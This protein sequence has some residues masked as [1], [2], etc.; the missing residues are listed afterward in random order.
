MTEDMS[1]SNLWSEIFERVLEGSEISDSRIL[2][3]EN[4]FIKSEDSVF[5]ISEFGN[6]IEVILDVC[7]KGLEN[8]IYEIGCGNGL[9]ISTMASLAKI[10]QYGGSYMSIN[11]I[12]RAQLIFPKGNWSTCD[13]LQDLNVT[14][15][16][17]VN[18]VLQYFPSQQY[19]VAFIESLEK[20]DLD[21]IAFLVIPKSTSSTTELASRGFINESKLFHLR[22][23][24]DWLLATFTVVMGRKYEFMSLPQLPLSYN[25]ETKRFNFF[26]VRK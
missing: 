18:S 14:G 17:F 9:F 15:F 4:G 12:R 8:S 5:S 2:L 6:Y 22:I 19:L 3:R 26:G 25:N 11:R 13:A 16:L 23:S 10:H 20:F 21:G 1:I 7:R 24:P